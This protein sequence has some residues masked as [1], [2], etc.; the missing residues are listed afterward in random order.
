[1]YEQ[2]FLTLPIDHGYVT[3]YDAV[4]VIKTWTALMGRRDSDAEVKGFMSDRV[5]S[6][7]ADRMSADVLDHSKEFVELV[8]KQAPLEY[9]KLLVSPRIESILSQQNNFNYGKLFAFAEFLVFRAEFRHRFPEASQPAC[10]NAFS[11]LFLKND[12]S[13]SNLVQFMEGSD[14]RNQLRLNTP[15]VS[16]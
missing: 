7:E 9:Q 8:S 12:I 4:M 3:Q 11:R 16:G 5:M 13:I 14:E 6:K 2:H 10:I 15:D 1:L